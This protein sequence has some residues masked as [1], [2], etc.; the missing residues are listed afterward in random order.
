MADSDFIGVIPAGYDK[1][2]L[3]EDRIV[4][5]WGNVFGSADLEVIWSSEPIDD[6]DVRS[7]DGHL[8]G[9]VS[10][11]DLKQVRDALGAHGLL[12]GGATGTLGSLALRPP[13]V[14]LCTVSVSHVF[15]DYI[16]DEA[17]ASTIVFCS[18]P[19]YSTRA[20][21]N[22]YM[23]T[24]HGMSKMASGDSGWVSP[25]DAPA[26]A[27]ADRSCV[28]SQ[29]TSW[30]NSGY[31][32]VITTSAKRLSMGWQMTAWRLLGCRG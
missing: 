26:V 15:W 13:S 8:S 23:F 32:S 17:E 3:A 16:D 22:I 4:I 21:T 2:S 10:A 5:T 11:S 20:K 6:F 31:G 19:V 7:G 30:R 14:V 25:A 18:G 12:E 28:S 24:G 1:A 27:K 29:A 9:V